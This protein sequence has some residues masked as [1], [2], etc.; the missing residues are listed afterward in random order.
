[1]TQTLRQNA[2]LSENPRTRVRVKALF[3][4]EHR[5]YFF[6]L[7]VVILL[8]LFGTIMVFSSS[9]VSDFASTGN[10]FTGLISQGRFVI[11]G[12]PIMLLA[13]RMP[14]IFWKKWALV[15]LGGACAFQLLILTTHMGSATGGNLNWVTIAGVTFQPSELIK[16]GI[17]LWLALS[18]T[19]LNAQTSDWRRMIGPI[20]LVPGAAIGLVMLG[21]DLGTSLILGLILFAGAYFA[22]VKLR[23]LAVS[24]VI[25]GIAVFLMV[26]SST[27]RMQR[28]MAFADK[29]GCIDYEGSCWQVT[30][31]SYA[32]SAGNIFG[33]GLGNSKAKWNWLPTAENDF[34]FAIIGEELGLAGAITVIALFVLL[35]IA[36]I[37]VIDANKS[38]PFIRVF[39]GSVLVWLVGQAF[40]NIAVVLQLAPV[41]GV[42]LPFISAGGSSLIA[43]MIAIGIVLSFS[44]S[45][46]DVV[47]L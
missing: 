45:G 19:R 25:A 10:A 39:T 38:D 28:I 12:I 17:A 23:Y 30:H 2:S 46:K 43:T 27:S 22:G 20:V 11:I 37:R 24:A 14:I 15:I 32:L 47:Q 6:L 40:I 41:L 1:M 31:A 4:V 26:I 13:S 21:W 7:G 36:L 16:V 35:A 3:S 8:I 42:P 33:V 9:S 18:F 34:I 29:G 5:N 44:K